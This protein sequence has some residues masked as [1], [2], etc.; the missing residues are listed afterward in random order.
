MR[1]LRKSKVF[2]VDMKIKLSGLRVSN[3]EVSSS[4]VF[5]FSKSY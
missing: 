4:G 1:G 5:N 3:S 2:T